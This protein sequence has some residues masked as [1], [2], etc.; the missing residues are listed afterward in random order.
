MRSYQMRSNFTKTE[1]NYFQKNS[2]VNNSLQTQ[3][4]FDCFSMIY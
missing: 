4:Y 3:T 2:S 1:T